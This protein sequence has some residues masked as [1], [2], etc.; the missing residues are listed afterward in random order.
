MYCERLEPK[1][2]SYFFNNSHDEAT[3]QLSVFENEINCQLSFK[4]GQCLQKNFFIKCQTTFAQTFNKIDSF[5]SK[6][7]MQIKSKPRSPS[8][9]KNG[10]S[11]FLCSFKYEFLIWFYIFSKIF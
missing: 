1:L 7:A 4:Y 11:L 5:N 2:M 6:C 10:G 8:H 3:M 9:A